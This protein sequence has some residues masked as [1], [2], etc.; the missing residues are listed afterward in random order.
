MSS[1]PFRKD[2]KRMTKLERVQ[3]SQAVVSEQIPDH[4][5][6]AKLTCKSQPDVDPN[7]EVERNLRGRESKYAGKELMDGLQY[8]GRILHERDYDNFVAIHLMPKET[9]GRILGMLALNAEI[10]VIRQKIK[11]N[12]GVT[13]IYQLQF[14]KDALMVMSGQ[15]PGPLPRQPVLKVLQAYWED[16]EIPMLMKLVEARQ[17]T[18]GDRPFETLEQLEFNCEC[19][20]ATQILAW[21]NSLKTAYTQRIKN[22]DGQ[23]VCADPTKEFAAFQRDTFLPKE[24]RSVEDVARQMGRAVGILITLRATIPLLREG[25]ILLPKD[26]MATHGLDEEVVARNTKPEALKNLVK[27]LCK[28]SE[29][30]LSYARN[31]MKLIPIAL[32]PALLVSG[33]RADHML[34]EFQRSDYNVTNA[35]LQTGNTFVSWR[36]KW[37]RYR[38]IY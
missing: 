27:D 16:D 20:Y 9:A 2:L 35:R 15:Q 5:V 10:S 31:G 13:G 24:A 17:E 30:Y 23:V 1:H 8:C 29:D 21:I 6:Y 33:I 28:V 14:W 4:M 26:A 32:R 37:R 22:S 18:L 11:R 34:R 19:V 7:V 12:S 3:Q 38:N 25:A 36:I